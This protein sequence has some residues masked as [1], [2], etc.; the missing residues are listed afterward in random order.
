MRLRYKKKRQRAPFR[1]IRSEQP[2][3]NDRRFASL[4]LPLNQIIEGDCIKL[5]LT[6]PDRSVDLIFADPPYNL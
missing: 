5:L 6:L 2:S 3:V 4:R 1:P